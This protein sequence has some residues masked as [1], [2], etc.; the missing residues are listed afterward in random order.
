MKQNVVIKSLPNGIRVGLDPSALFDTIC[1][2]VKQ[3][4][5]ECAAFFKD[6]RVAISFD[7]RKLTT[8]E[9]LKLVNI[10]CEVSDITP[11]CVV[12][13]DYDE[14]KIYARSLE[15]TLSELD[16]QCVLHVG[17]IKDGAHNKWEKG[18]VI[19]GDVFPGCTVEAKGSIIVIGGLYGEAYAGTDWKDDRFVIANDMS[20][21]FLAIGRLQFRP[22][23]KSKWPILSKATPHIAYIEN[24][25]VVSSEINKEIWD[26]LPFRI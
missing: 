25:A 3:K 16:H 2:E 22:E 17:N 11:I 12:E 6:A 21:Q 20:P 19:L 15:M 23:K 18:V 9:E 24:G 13:K 1:E 7:G 10:I 14:N 26:R 5:S 8:E 4:F